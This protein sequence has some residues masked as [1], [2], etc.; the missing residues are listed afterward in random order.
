MSTVP[1]SSTPAR[2]RLSMYSRVRDL[3]DDRLDALAVQQQ[4]QHETGRTGPHDAY[5]GAH[6]PLLSYLKMPEMVTTA[7]AAV[8]RACDTAQ[9]G[10]SNSTER[11]TD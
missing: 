4:R 1:C 8:E 10:A 5:L 11:K 3:E 7:G 9:G 2:T 6:A